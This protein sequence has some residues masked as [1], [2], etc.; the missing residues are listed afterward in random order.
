MYGDYIYYNVQINVDK[1]AGQTNIYKGG[2]VEMDHFVLQ[3]FWILNIF[4]GINKQQKKGNA[5]RLL[6]DIDT[7]CMMTLCWDEM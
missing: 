4:R 6:A 1:S 2:R 7:T 3:C 5:D